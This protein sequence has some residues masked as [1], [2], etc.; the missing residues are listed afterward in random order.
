MTVHAVDS[1]ETV[2]RP[3]AWG[4]H[5]LGLINP[6]V[7][8]AGNL[9]GGWFTAAGVVY[10]LGIGPVLDVVL[11]KSDYHKRPS[12][13]SG[14]PFEVMLFAHAL[15]QLLAVGTLLFL[16][17]SESPVWTVVVAAVSTGINS[18]ASGLIV[19]H[20]LGHR[21]KKSFSWWI[22]Q[23]NLFSVLY[24]HFTTE[25]NRTH[26][27]HVAT[28]ADP[29]TARYGE[30]VWWFVA[31]TVPGQFLDAW[32]LH[33]VR[34]H[35][36]ITNPVAR[37]AA[38]EMLLVVSIAVFLG[39]IPA[40]AF[41]IQ[42]ASAV[43]LLEYI[44]YLRHYG[45]QRDVGSR[46]TATH[47]WQSENRWSR[48]TLLELTRHPAHHLEAGKPFWKLRPYEDAPEL[49]SGYY[50]CFWVALVP[51]LWR[52]LIHPRLPSANT[53]VGHKETV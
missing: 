36:P 17:T 52:G 34:G 23:L 18:G 47:S 37:G 48:W 51:P 12:R 9:L 45:L 26:H 15:L 5:L 41:L 40:L 46:Q 4:W 24:L 19:A 22:S 1:Q 13:D 33:A 29:A 43:F 44:N 35:S 32:R 53:L 25:H 21:R 49:P 16:A 14:Q 10:M 27:K 6:F 2:S 39:P 30:S 11:G 42:A 20:E 50:G 8:I 31:R 7:V 28:A 3:E 38:C